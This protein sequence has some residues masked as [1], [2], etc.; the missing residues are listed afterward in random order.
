M[1]YCTVLNC[2]IN[3]VLIGGLLLCF[4]VLFIDNKN[5]VSCPCLRI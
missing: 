1:G 4:V 2:E 3:R 5:F